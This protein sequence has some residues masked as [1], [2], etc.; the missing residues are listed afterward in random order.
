MSRFD[1]IINVALILAWA[2]VAYRFGTM[3]FG[4]HE[5]VQDNMV[6]EYAE[7]S[8]PPPVSLRFT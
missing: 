3:Y 8:P 5:Q 1:K 2:L 6:D 4:A 7:P